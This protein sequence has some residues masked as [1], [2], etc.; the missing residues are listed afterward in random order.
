MGGDFQYKVDIFKYAEKHGLYFSKPFLDLFMQAKK[1][2]FLKG[3]KIRFPYADVAHLI[4]IHKGAVLGILSH[5]GKTVYKTIKIASSIF[6]TD[7]KGFSKRKIDSNEWIAANKSELT[8]IPIG[9]LLKSLQSVEGAHDKLSAH[10]KKMIKTD[11]NLYRE[12][13]EQD[14]MHDK[15]GF[16]VK[17]YPSLFGKT[18]K[19][20]ANYMNVSQN[21]LSKAIKKW[22]GT[23]FGGK[24]D[25]EN[26]R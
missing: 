6:L 10:I 11:Y 14:S 9:F 1:V 21:G 13:I 18:R 20:V 8:A 26:P 19:Y 23:N 5:K 24:E 3:E 25:D 7:P 22:E 4:F 2:V 12:M 16:L 15:V 17:T